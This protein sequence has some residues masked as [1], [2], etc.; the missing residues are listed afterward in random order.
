MTALPTL[1]FIS[2]DFHCRLC[3]HSNMWDEVLVEACRPVCRHPHLQWSWPYFDISDWS[4]FSSHLFFLNIFS[5]CLLSPLIFFPSSPC[6]PFALLSFPVWFHWVYNWFPLEGTCPF[7]SCIPLHFVLCHCELLIGKRSWSQGG[8]MLS[9]FNKRAHLP[10][11]W[12]CF[13]Y[14]FVY[15][16]VCVCVYVYARLC[17]HRVLLM[18]RV[19][20]S[21]VLS[22]LLQSLPAKWTPVVNRFLVCVRLM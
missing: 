10:F 22:P 14:M 9:T 8:D 19:V 7:H 2:S 11:L 5:S 3:T 18:D 6:C 1:H 12:M 16:F 13:V 15:S 20:Q 4:Y 21:P 17:L